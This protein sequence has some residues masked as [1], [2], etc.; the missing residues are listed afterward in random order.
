MSARCP[1]CGTDT[2]TT[3]GHDTDACCQFQQDIAGAVESA[4]QLGL[5]TDRAARLVGSIGTEIPAPHRL[6]AVLA[7]LSSWADTSVGAS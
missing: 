6:P 1:G 7:A 4:R 3:I 5:P 2:D